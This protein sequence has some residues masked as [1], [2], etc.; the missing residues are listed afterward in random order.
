LRFSII[1][2]TYNS[3][4]YLEE[5]I[6]SVLS[7]DFA[8]FEYIIVDGGSTDGTLDLIKGYAEKDSRIRWVSE[9]DE[10]IADAFNKG[11]AAATGELVGIINSDDSYVP[12]ALHAVAESYAAH[13]ECDVFHGDILRFQDDQPLFRLKPSDVERTI[14]HGMPLN[15]PATFVTARAYRKVEGYDKTFRVAMD[16]DL[17]LRM[18]KAGCRFCYI[19][20]VLANMRYGGESDASF[21]VGL[22]EV[23]RASVREGYPRHKAYLWMYFKVMLGLIKNV[24]RRTGLYSL[25]RLHPKFHEIG[26]NESST[27]GR[28]RES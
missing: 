5:T 17:L 19:D 6:Q 15:H 26:K 24:M 22:R 16:Y 8:D 1:T 9:P 11:I 18:A 4:C 3:E 25:M 10:G 7:Q 2:I 12:G 21:L 20:Q 23:F 13:P 28:E 14:W 27:I